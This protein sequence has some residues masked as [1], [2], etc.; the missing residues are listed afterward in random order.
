MHTLAKL[1]LVQ[2]IYCKIDIC[3]RYM[4]HD[5]IVDQ[6]DCN[7]YI[8][9][10]FLYILVDLCIH[11]SGPF[12]GPFFVWGGGGR[13]FFRPPPPPPPSGMALLCT[14]HVVVSLLCFFPCGMAIARGH[15][16]ILYMVMELSLCAKFYCM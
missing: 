9:W 13:G 1:N 12:G 5:A 10:T 3:I 8:Y 7:S 2:I 15:L 11:S 14:L 4:Q 6:V 16:L